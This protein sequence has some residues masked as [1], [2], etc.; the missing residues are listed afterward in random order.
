MQTVATID[1]VDQYGNKDYQQ[2]LVLIQE[3]FNQR[4]SDNG[5]A[6]F[7][8]DTEGLFDLFL[9]KLP[10]EVRQHY[11]CNACRRFVDTFGGLV[12][13]DKDGFVWPALWILE[14]TP[15]MFRAAVTAVFLRVTNAKVTGVYLNSAT[16]WGQPVTGEWHHMALDAK[17]VAFKPTILTASQVMAEKK[18]DY[19]IL[20]DGLNEFPLKAVETAITLLET[21]S[22]YRSEKCLGVAKWLAELHNKR[23]S[24]KKQT[25]KTSL[26]WQAVATAPAGWCHIRSTMIGTLL[27]DIVNGLDFEAV[28]RRFADKMHPLQYQRP[29]APPTAGNIAQAEKVI[30]KL[31]AAGSLDRRF[32]RLEEIKAIWRP[33]PPA[34]PAA[35]NGIFAHLQPKGQKPEPPSIKIPKQTMTWVK[36]LNT[37]LPTAKSIELFIPD[38]R[39][40][41]AA[42]VTAVDPEAPP[43]IQW[44]FED[45]RNP[46]SWYLYH[47]W[48]EAGST[49]ADWNLQVGYCKVTAVCYRPSMWHETRQFTQH[50]ESVLFVL[51][52]A[53][54]TRYRHSGNALFP[55]ILKSEFHGIR[56]TIEAYSKKAV[57]TGYEEATANGLLLGVGEGEKWDVTLLVDGLEY[58]LDRWD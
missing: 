35:G 8:T 22:L 27:E 39:H 9:S 52:G 17:G 45:C 3:A 2:F 42:L 13:I 5:K 26:T 29:Q 47:G 30:E 24:T 20:I 58:T 16:T 40:N 43:I 57:I 33:S 31:K 25:Q 15:S 1:M 7:T 51:E 53:K 6:L 48:G 23:N 41:F 21:D 11:T 32:A 54:D 44:D 50:K 4:I 49:P 46:F 10:D 28:S 19:R 56:A 38:K 18:E 55:E 12:S 37:V 36:F 34:Q 14:G